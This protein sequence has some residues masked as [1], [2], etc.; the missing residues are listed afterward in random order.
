MVS[1][2]FFFVVSPGG[3]GFDEKSVTSNHSCTTQPF[4]LFF[5]ELPW[6]KLFQ[7]KLRI[8]GLAFASTK[9]TLNVAF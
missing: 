4:E 3:V 8:L 2:S 7:R 5:L 1:G 9:S 6:P